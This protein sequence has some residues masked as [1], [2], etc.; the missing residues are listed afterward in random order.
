MIKLGV[1]GVN[2]LCRRHMVSC[3]CPLGGP[4]PPLALLDCLLE[5]DIWQVTYLWKVNHT[6]TLEVFQKTQKEPMG[7]RTIV[8]VAETI[9]IIQ[10]VVVYFGV[11]VVPAAFSSCWASLSSRWRSS[12]C[13][14]ARYCWMKLF[15]LISSPICNRI[16]KTELHFS[17]LYTVETF[18]QFLQ[19]HC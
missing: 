19:M 3:C 2:W 1:C 6:T 18:H 17:C 8:S 13:C 11:T 9:V 5:G 14:F 10:F 7:K 4:H 15:W 12:S 16:H